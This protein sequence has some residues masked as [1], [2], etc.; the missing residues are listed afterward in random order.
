MELARSKA[1]KRRNN[2]YDLLEDE[3]FQRAGRDPVEGQGHLM[4]GLLL[5]GMDIVNRKILQQR[6]S[7]QT[8]R[9]YIHVRRPTVSDAGC[10]YFNLDEHK[11]GTRRQVKEVPHPLTGSPPCTYI[12]MFPSMDANGGEQAVEGALPHGEGE[13][14]EARRD[15]FF[16]F[17]GISWNRGD[18]Y[19]LHEHPQFEIRWA[20]PLAIEVAHGHCADFMV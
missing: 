8:S 2:N 7:V 9:R 18:T 4:E 13:G 20:F 11:E 1:V 3:K 5:D 12:S 19:V 14:E 17:T 15:L 6:L 16:Q 10:K